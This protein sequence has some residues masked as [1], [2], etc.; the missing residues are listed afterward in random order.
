MFRITP[1]GAEKV[2]YSF[3]GA[4]DGA[5]PEA[6]VIAVNGVLYGTT[7]SGGGNCSGNFCGTVFRVTTAGKETVLYRFKGGK[8]GIGPAGGLTYV[9][10]KLYGTTNIGGA[11]G[12]GTVFE[13]SR[14]HEKV[15]HTF[16]GTFSKDGHGPTGNLTDVKGVLYGTTTYGGAYGS[17][18]GTSGTV[19]AIAT[20]GAYK[21]I[22]SFKGPDGGYPLYT[23]LVDVKGVLYG[24]TNL[25]GA[26][27]NGT[28]F[29][30]TKA[31]GERVLHSFKGGKKDGAMPYGGPIPINGKLYGV[32]SRGGTFNDGIIY[33]V[34]Q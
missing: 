17:G 26:N 24:T 23:T 1:A 33:V 30:V 32:A 10:G 4:N 27:N 11:G 6:G 21:V 34:T 28:V 2:I 9:K 12:I 18:S 13:F 20:S 16:E 19:Y 3:K 8:D 31:G 25:G 29:A 14:T 5:N 22:Y 15:L 7:V